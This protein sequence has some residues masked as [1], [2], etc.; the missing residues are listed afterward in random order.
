MLIRRFLAWI[1]RAPP[2]ERAEAAT[3][4]AHAYLY[5]DLDAPEQ[6]EAERALTG[7]LDDP[8]PLVR[9][10]LAEAIA[11]AI[12]APHHLVVAL[13]GD[14]PEI[15]AIV[16]ARSP[17]LSDVELIDAVAVGGDL[18]QAA[19][20]RRPRVSGALAG[21]LADIAGRDAVIA[22]CDNHDA[23]LDARTFH[24]ILARF[25]GD[26]AVREA[27]NQRPDL[28]PGLRHALAAAAA[29]ALRSFVTGQG[30]MSAERAR[31]ATGEARDR[32]TMTI[33]AASL[34]DDADDLG[35]FVAHLRDS[36][37]LTPALV[38]RALL[39]GQSGL[40]AAALSEL[41]GKSPRQVAGL[42]HGRSGLGFAALYKKSGM[43]P[44]LR[45]AFS[46][47][48]A[49]LADPGA[50]ASADPGLR[51]RMVACVLARCLRLEGEGADALVALLRR[52]EAEAAR[53]EA[54][55][56]VKARPQG[57]FAP[58]AS[59]RRAALPHAPPPHLLAAA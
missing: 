32:A 37:H 39:S 2:G 9:R 51:R 52:F 34:R 44:S 31:R 48:L 38:L 14:V 50:D 41:T 4:L 58:T 19:V 24:R 27:L 8:S 55:A 40:F 22:L 53:D 30:W 26:G 45:P 10:A 46:A 57:A 36:G 56:A 13:S 42:L 15:A 25:G 59:T 5:A 12:E 23:A 35:G 17:I 29:D 1:E 47:A 28:D 21:A 54:R 7:L 11:G 33:A 49:G 6:G 20:A 18:A 16:L 43:P 3:A